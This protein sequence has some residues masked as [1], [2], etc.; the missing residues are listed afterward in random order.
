MC[1]FFEIYTENSDLTYRYYYKL[2]LQTV[3][4]HY[5][6]ILL[7]PVY[8]LFQIPQRRDSLRYHYAAICML[9]TY[10][11]MCMLLSVCCS[12][13]IISPGSALNS[14][15]LFLWSLSLPLRVRSDPVPDPL[16]SALFLP[17]GWGIADTRNRGGYLSDQLFTKKTLR[18]V[19][20]NFYIK[21]SLQA[22][23]HPF[24]FSS[25]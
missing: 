15:S 7:F 14:P 17:G 9:Y 4:I 10:L 3:I 8:Y 20:T 24:I 12:G 2:L 19:T 23:Y 16:R 18:I 13:Y 11:F 25:K 22:A 5:P 6:C 1:N 21:G